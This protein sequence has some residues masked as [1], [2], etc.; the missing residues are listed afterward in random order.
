LPA[1]LLFRL[2]EYKFSALR[3]IMSWLSLN[4]PVSAERPR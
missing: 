4:S 2:R 3:E 1:L